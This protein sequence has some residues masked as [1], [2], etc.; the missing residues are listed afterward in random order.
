MKL[1]RD[2]DLHQT[3]NIEKLRREV[4][5]TSEISGKSELSEIVQLAIY[6]LPPMETPL[7]TAPYHILVLALNDLPS[8]ELCLDGSNFHAHPVKTGDWIFIPHNQI[9]GSRWQDNSQCMHVYLNQIFVDNLLSANFYQDKVSFTPLIGYRDS[10]IDHFLELF[11]TEFVSNLLT[12]LLYAETLAKALTIHL[13]RCCADR[14]TSRISTCKSL[15]QSELQAIVSYIEN[16][17]D[18]EITIQKLA[19]Q[20]KISMSVFAHTFRKVI[21][22][23]PYQFILQKRLEK[24]KQLLLEGN[25]T[26]SI[27]TIAQKCGF[28]NASAFT[29]HFRQKQGISPSQYRSSRLSP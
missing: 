3:S 23:S 27:A 16:N 25:S 11:R 21:G 6:N 10:T 15:C 19:Q 2:R 5:P 1:T 13:V 7:F 28:S 9:S 29:K 4:V 12:D 17:L 20:A 18:R 26:M 14:Q 8:L 22:I 24:S